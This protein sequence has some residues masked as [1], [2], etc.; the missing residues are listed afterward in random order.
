VISFIKAL[1]LIPIGISPVFLIDDWWVNFRR[2]PAEA[3]ALRRASYG[4]VLASFG[5]LWLFYTM[6]VESDFVDFPISV[7][8]I[9]GGAYLFA[10]HARECR[11][12]TDLDFI[13][14][15]AGKMMVGVIG[16]WILWSSNR[17]DVVLG[18]RIM[19]FITGSSPRKPLS[20]A[21]FIGLHVYLGF[22]ALWLAIT[23][24]AKLYLLLRDG[25]AAQ[26]S[27]AL[28]YAAVYFF[29]RLMPE[30]TAAPP[31]G[32]KEMAARHSSTTQLACRAD[33]RN[34]LPIAGVRRHRSTQSEIDRA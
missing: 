3:I 11:G 2:G 20:D 32:V 15:A 17:D 6:V 8:T 30:K 4:A 31:M 34:L 1:L 27:R 28:Q 16:F 23:G 21:V 5:F 26:T 29:G 13:A 22:C 19:N 24:G 25:N 33:G 10:R 7:V 9:A 12:F 14:R 18:E